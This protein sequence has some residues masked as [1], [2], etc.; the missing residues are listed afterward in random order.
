MKSVNKMAFVVAL[1][2]AGTSVNA[3]VITNAD[4]NFDFGGVDWAS[5]GSV[6]VDN[7]PVLQVPGATT[8]AGTG[9]NFTLTYMAHAIAVQDSTGAN[10]GSGAMP[11]LNNSYEY[12]VWAEITETATCLNGDC[13]LVQIDVV[14]GNWDVY[15]DTTPDFD[16]AVGD[17]VTN[18]VNI[19]SGDFAASP[20]SQSIVA[21]QGTTNPG[22][23]SLLASL[24]GDVLSTNNT[25][26]N[27]DLDASTAVSTL[28]FGDTTTAWTRPATF[29]GTNPGDNSNT[30]F[31]GQADANQSFQKVP[32]PSSLALLSLGLVVFG[33][34][35]QR[36]RTY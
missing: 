6:W 32:E 11:G 31:V 35:Q 16:P 2:F 29:D 21:T 18:S 15:Y 24:K 7:Y 17:N 33:F 30:S 5:N 12:T 19:L 34:A 3:A 10:Y 13:S 9:G 8:L 27:P 22:D 4:G 26:I 20:T 14:S 1:A 36:R 23:V 25:Y 28:Q